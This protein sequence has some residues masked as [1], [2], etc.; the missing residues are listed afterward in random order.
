MKMKARAFAPAKINLSLHI[1]GQRADGYHLIDS[2]VA[3]ADVGDIVTVETGKGA[4]LSVTGPAAQGVPADE[5]NLVCRIARAFWP[6][7]DVHIQLEK[8][9]PSA[10]GIGGGSADA[11][12]C[13]RAMSK[14]FPRAA[15]ADVTSELLQIGADVPMCVSG[16]PARVG[17]VGEILDPIDALA[18]LPAVLVNPGI[19]VSTPA[20]FAALECRSNAAMGVLPDDMSD[21]AS[22]A[23]WLSRQRNDMQQAAIAQVPQISAVLDH[24][25]STSGC[26]FSR[27]SGS[28]ATC[29]GIYPA[30]ADAKAAAL[31]LAAERPDW[32]VCFAVLGSPPQADA[33]LMRSTT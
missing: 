8:H 31:Q 22:V 29:F 14:L 11:A 2:I 24:I 30:P 4:G 5:S 28:G 6:D 9:L 26:A 25:A 20:V 27:M 3:F 7:A 21:P 13:F 23:D 1:T 12:A 18:S 32:W 10:S 16:K 19:P 17:G 15:A 33:Q